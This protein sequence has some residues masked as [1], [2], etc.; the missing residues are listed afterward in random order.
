MSLMRHFH[1]QDVRIEARRVNLHQTVSR[2][3]STVRVEED[4]NEE[5]TCLF[6]LEKK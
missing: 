3:E 6:E 1:S 4:S 2:I 5:D